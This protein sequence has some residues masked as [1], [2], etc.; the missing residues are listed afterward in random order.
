MCLTSAA[1]AS[2]FMQKALAARELRGLWEATTDASPSRPLCVA[3]LIRVQPVK[4]VLEYVAFSATFACRRRQ[5]PAL[6][7]VMF[8]HA[9]FLL[10]A[11]PPLHECWCVQ[12]RQWPLPAVSAGSCRQKHHGSTH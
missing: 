4:N 5:W 11:T 8:L 1:W 6:A 9:S 3:H 10:K 12:V 7:L 2:G